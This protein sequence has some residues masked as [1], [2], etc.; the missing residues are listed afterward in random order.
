MKNAITLCAGC[1]IFWAHKHPLD[2]YDWIRERMGEVAF[3]LLRTKSDLAVSI[4]TQELA[5]LLRV[6][7]QS[8]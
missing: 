2:F 4:S 3:K 1:H 8:E 7:P 5:L 6:G